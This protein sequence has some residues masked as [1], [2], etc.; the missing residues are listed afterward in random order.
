MVFQLRRARSRAKQ[1]FVALGELGGLGFWRRIVSRVAGTR[2]KVQDWWPGVAQ[3]WPAP[4][5]ISCD[6]PMNSFQQ[7]R[8][9]Q[10]SDS[11]FPVGAF[12]YSDGLEA[13]V[14]SGWVQDAQELGS[15]MENW[16]ES[17]F[18]LCEGRALVQAMTVWREQDWPKLERLDA[19]LTA[20]KPASAI[21]KSSATLGTRLLKTALPLFPETDLATLET[22][23]AE[24]R[25]QGNQVLVQGVLYAGLDLSR[26]DALSAFSY[27]RLNG[28][29]SAALRLFDIGQQQGQQVLTELLEAVPGACQKVLS[30]P[31]APLCTFAPW[32]DLAQMNHRLLYTRLFRS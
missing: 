31:D 10:L 20:L 13:A 8:L 11:A 5:K 4:K 29:V 18:V 26:E 9:L 14:Q 25:L 3:I 28:M 30:A 32:M 27:V 16:L 17:V 22:K 6:D 2:D 21:R 19:E 1:K 23:I 24:G 15:W 12:A 7:L